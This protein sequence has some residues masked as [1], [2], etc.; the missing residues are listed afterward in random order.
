MILGNDAARPSSVAPR[1]RQR[2]PSDSL[3]DRSSNRRHI[4]NVLVLV[5]I[6]RLGLRARLRPSFVLPLKFSELIFVD[7]EDAVGDRYHLC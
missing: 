5:L 6:T 4:Y 7:L 3:R 1:P 2:P